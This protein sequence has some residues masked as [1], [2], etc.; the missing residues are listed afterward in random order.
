MCRR[1][2]AW[3]SRNSRNAKRSPFVCVLVWVYFVHERFESGFRDVTLCVKVLRTAASFIGVSWAHTTRLNC[4]QGVLQAQGSWAVHP[5]IAVLSTH[6]RKG[7]RTS[8]WKCI[9]PVS[10]LVEVMS[11]GN[12]FHGLM[13]FDI[14]LHYQKQTKL[15]W[16]P[17]K[18]VTII[19]SP[20]L[21][22]HL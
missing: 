7:M 15:Q 8:V 5:S 4:T 22:P 11:N 19:P 1:E 9:W 21:P 6:W 2:T 12:G 20:Y 10:M 3:E 13:C 17:P 16:R 18:K 14:I